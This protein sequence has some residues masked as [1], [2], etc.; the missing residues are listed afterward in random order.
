MPAKPGYDLPM[1]WSLAATPAAFAK[2]LDLLCRAQQAILANWQVAADEWFKHHRESIAASQEA[3]DQ[4]LQ[5][6]DI[7]Q[8]ASMQQKWLTGMMDR[9]SADIQSCADTVLALSRETG[10]Q[11]PDSGSA[12]RS[13]A[14]RK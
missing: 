9:I 11:A 4:M 5:C 12:P 3:C 2:Q 13:A 6:R 10:Q 1:A 7:G 8:L 14:P